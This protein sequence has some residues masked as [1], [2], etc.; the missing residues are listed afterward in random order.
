MYILL[1]NID[2]YYI[3]IYQ[4][5]WNIYTDIYSNIYFPSYTPIKLPTNKKKKIRMISW[6]KIGDFEKNPR[7]IERISAPKILSSSNLYVFEAQHGDELVECID[8]RQFL[9]LF[10]RGEMRQ[11]KGLVW[12]TEVT[13]VYDDPIETKKQDLCFQIEWK[14]LWH[15]VMRRNLRDS[16][17]W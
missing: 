2:I 11:Q 3:Y 17:T 10:S 15:N 8:L 16:I 6:T 5:I 9:R 4:N 7:H 13:E 14:C 12:R 1:F